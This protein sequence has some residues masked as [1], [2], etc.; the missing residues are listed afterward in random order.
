[1]KINQMNFIYLTSKKYPSKTADHFF[2]MEMA[3]AY[4]RLLKDKLTL[5]LAGDTSDFFKDI[6]VV[7]TEILNERGRTPYYFFWLPYFIMKQKLNNSETVFFSNDPN[8]LVDLVVL[9]KIFRFKYKICSEWHMLYDSW[10]DAYIV[11]NSDCLVATSKRL[12]DTILDRTKVAIDPDKFLVVYG[13][14]NIEKYDKLEGRDLRTELNLPKDKILVAYI[15]MF[16]TLGTT[17]GIDMMIESLSYLPDNVNMVFVGGKHEEIDDIKKEIVDP[18]IKERVIFVERQ[19]MER[20]PMYQKAIDILVIPSPDKP[21]F[22]NYLLPM[23]VYE[24][25]ASCKPVVFSD[26]P[27]LQEILGDCGFSFKPGDAKDLARVILFINGDPEF[28]RQKTEMCYQ[29]AKESTWDR[30]AQNIIDFLAK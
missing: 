30:R 7:N 11:K 29:K 1:M 20:V 15:G 18:K 22:S 6:K 28:V 17:K 12:R 24:Y 9:R 10:K 8:L 4:G 14:A 19:D 21:P 27:I 23:K 16:K 25:I 26:L 3:Q 2:V 5:V 13:G